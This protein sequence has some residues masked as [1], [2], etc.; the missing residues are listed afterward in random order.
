M[1]HNVD[2][3]Q[4]L[5]FAEGVAMLLA[6]HIGKARAHALL[7]TLSRQTVAEK[8]HLLD[9]TLDA[10]AQDAALKAK[11]SAAELRAVFDADASARRANATAQAQWADLRARAAALDASAL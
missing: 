9:V 2:A 6:R 4:G 5:V 3:L 11:V 8:R 10:L 1:R 7:E